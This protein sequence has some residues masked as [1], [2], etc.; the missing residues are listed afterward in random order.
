MVDNG[1]RWMKVMVD[2]GL[3]GCGDKRIFGSTQRTHSMT[4]TLRLRERHDSPVLQTMIQR[5][6]YTKAT[7]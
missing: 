6:F 4:T 7:C 5:D 1:G 3:P 2:D